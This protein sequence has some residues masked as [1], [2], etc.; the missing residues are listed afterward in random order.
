[1]YKLNFVDV[2]VKQLQENKPIGL[3][4]FLN[5]HPVLESGWVGNDPKLAECLLIG[6]FFFLMR[7]GS[8]RYQR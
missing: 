8:K 4:N 2:V 7:F 6:L 1:M 5:T 3:F